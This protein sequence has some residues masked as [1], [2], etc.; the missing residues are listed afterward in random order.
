V[1]AA[2]GV[3]NVFKYSSDL[4]MFRRA[5]KNGTAD[6]TLLGDLAAHHGGMWGEEKFF[7]PRVRLDDA[8]GSSNDMFKV[9]DNVIAGGKEVLGYMNGMNQIKNMQQQIVAISQANRVI[10]M[11]K[12]GVDNP[13][14]L[15][16]FKSIGWDDKMLASFKSKIDD[17]TVTFQKNGNIDMLNLEKWD[18]L[19]AENF[20]LGLH[21]HSG[22]LIQFPQIGETAYWMHGTL[23]S[24]LTQFRSY[25][26]VAIEKQLGRNIRMADPE[27]F[28]TASYGLAFS[29]MLYMSKVQVTSIGRKDRQ[30]YL[31]ERLNAGAIFNGALQWSGIFS[32]ATELMN[33]SAA[34][35]LIPS[36][37]ST[38][39]VGRS[40]GS[41][42]SLDSNVPAVSVAKN[43]MKFTTGTMTSISPLNENRFDKAEIN[44][45]FG[46]MVL[47]N[48]LPMIW[49]KNVIHGKLDEVK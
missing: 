18:D 14:L 6:K 3:A 49:L 21:T 30:A 41:A 39:S 22:Q 8:S 45:G 43:L 29:S 32:G 19:T 42:Y 5:V 26:I 20:T 44:A 40:G 15:K 2:H 16:R 33:V 34:T 27:S 13:R 23:G 47:G 36:N 31:D 48:T 9:L 10:K 46:A 25:P 24:S 11:L 4:R 28:L 37:W 1:F 38:G 7:R 12:S 17:G 35:G